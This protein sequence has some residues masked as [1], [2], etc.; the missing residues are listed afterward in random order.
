MSKTNEPDFDDISYVLDLSEVMARL[1]QDRLIQLINKEIASSANGS[2]PF[3][4]GLL[5]SIA[6]IE[7]EQ[8]N[9]IDDYFEQKL[10]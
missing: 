4:D 6:I 10:F 9:G 2:D 7:E 8:T 3:I 1:E 5:R